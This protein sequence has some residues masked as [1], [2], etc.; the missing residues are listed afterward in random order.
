M[1]TPERPTPEE[2]KKNGRRAIFN[3][4]SFSLYEGMPVQQEA[5]KASLSADWSHMSCV[6][7]KDNIKCLSKSTVLLWEGESSLSRV[8]HESWGR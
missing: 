1:W 3:A 6:I 7:E 4:S 5:D 2:E 8:A